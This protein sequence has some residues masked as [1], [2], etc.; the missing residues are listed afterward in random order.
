MVLSP[1]IISGHVYNS[2][3]TAVVDCH[4]YAYNVTKGGYMIGADGISNSSGE[5]QIDISDQTIATNADGYVVGDKLQLHFIKGNQSVMARRTIASGD[6]GAWSQDGYLH[7]AK[8]FSFETDDNGLAY[9]KAGC[10]VSSVLVS[11]ITSTARTI[12]LFDKTNDN[13][14]VTIECPVNSSLSHSFGSKS[15]YFEGGLGILYEVVTND[16]T[17]NDLECDINY[18]RSEV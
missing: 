4:V 2:E 1:Y 9:T 18:G 7:N 15:K 3:D 17:Y 8:D 5:Y 6:A 13:P 16:G 11:N 12:R 10:Y 14:V